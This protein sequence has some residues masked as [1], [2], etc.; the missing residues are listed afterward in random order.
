V[1]LFFLGFG[2]KTKEERNRENGFIN[3]TI[4]ENDQLIHYDVPLY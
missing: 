3:T 4:A 2:K 1:A